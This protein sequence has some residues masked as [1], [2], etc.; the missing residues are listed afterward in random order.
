MARKAVPVGTV[1]SA[2]APSADD[3]RFGHQVSGEFRQKWSIANNHRRIDEVDRI[4]KR[5]TRAARADHLPWHVF[6]YEDQKFKNAAATRGNHIFVWTAMIDATE[7]ES[8]LATVLAH[9]IAH[10]L[11]GHVEPDP[12]EQLTQVLIGLGASIAGGAIGRSQGSQA[13]GNVAT[14][15]TQEVG[16]GIFLNPYSREK[17]YEADQVGLFLMADAGYNPESAI[18]FWK[19][20]END[21][22]FSSS[23]EFFSTHPPALGRLSKLESYLPKAKARYQSA[24]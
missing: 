3:E 16:Q 14:S 4:V 17:E 8:E 5:L 6:V 10:V 9:E 12:N 20:A 11:T 13:L 23:L 22:S 21:P 19:R 15:L 7:N 1:P 24:R 2:K 18:K